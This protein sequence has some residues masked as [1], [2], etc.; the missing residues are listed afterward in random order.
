MDTFFFY[1]ILDIEILFFP[2]RHQPQNRWVDGEEG[3]SAGPQA[4]GDLGDISATKRVF[5]EQDPGGHH[6]RNESHT[7]RLT[8]GPKLVGREGQGTTRTY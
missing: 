3:V 7:K 1:F 4:Y 6:S 2:L 5:P 8:G